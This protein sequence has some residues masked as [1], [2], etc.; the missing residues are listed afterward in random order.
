MKRKKL[1][2]AAGASVL[3]LGLGAAAIEAAPT[4]LSGQGQG[5]FAQHAGFGMGRHGGDG[6]MGG[7]GMRG[8]CRGD[9]GDR[10][11]AM[12]GVVDEFFDFTPEQSEKWDE[13]TQALAAGQASMKAACGDVEEASEE[14]GASERL[15]RMETMMSAGLGVIQD[16]RPAFEAFYET[17]TEAQQEALD[18]LFS[19]GRRH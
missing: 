12:T 16:I 15:A 1:L 9:H 18:G 19:M 14:G 4:A 17:L 3:A 5:M 2:M 13:L 7:H 8:M 11:E 10:I 6:G